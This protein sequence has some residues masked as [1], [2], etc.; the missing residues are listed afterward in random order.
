[1][2]VGPPCANFQ[3][4]ICLDAYK[5]AISLIQKT[6][7]FTPTV[8]IQHARLIANCRNM[9]L[10]YASYQIYL[11]RFEE[12]KGETLEQGRALLWSEVRGLRV[13]MA[14]LTSKDDPPLAMRFTE[15]NQE[16]EALTI[17]IT[18]SG[19]PEMKAG[20]AQ[21]GDG[22]DPF[23][24]LVVKRQK[25]VEG[26]NALLLPIQGRPGLEGFLRAPSFTAL[27]PAA[28]RGPVILINHCKWRSD[29]LIVFHNFLPYSIAT[30]N[31]FY[32]RAY[33]L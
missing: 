6:L 32:H 15:T 19:G 7:S 23:G 11:G 27:R 25:L 31:N 33:E 22:M 28:S 21:G 29:I 1:M 10:D 12:A 14:Q 5:S 20:V 30:A 9:P 4:S 8:S 18:P 17:A 26:R 2:S 24:R 13:P 16:L 3:S